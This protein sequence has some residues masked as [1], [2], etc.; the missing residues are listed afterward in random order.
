MAMLSI[1]LV[2]GQQIPPNQFPELKP[3]ADVAPTAN[4]TADEEDEGFTKKRDLWFIQQR[5]FSIRPYLAGGADSR[6][7]RAPGTQASQ[8][9]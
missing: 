9:P 4:T 1:P 2:Y 7:E 5:A 3:K 8:R 6:S